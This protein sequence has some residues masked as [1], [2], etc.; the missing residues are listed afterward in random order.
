MPLKLPVSPRPRHGT[1]AV[2]VEA[3][4]TIVQ[5]TTVF[6]AL[7]GLETF[8]QLLQRTIVR[9]YDAEDDAEEPAAAQVADCGRSDSALPVPLRWAFSWLQ[10]WRES[11]SSLE[12]AHVEGRHPNC[13]YN[14]VQTARC[15]SCV[16]DWIQHPAEGGQGMPCCTVRLL[17]LHCKQTVGIPEC[18]SG[19]CLPRRA[20]H[21]MD[22]NPLHLQMPCQGTCLHTCQACALHEGAILACRL[23][24]F[25]LWSV[26]SPRLLPA[27]AVQALT[28]TRSSPSI[29]TKRITKSITKNT[30]KSTTR[31]GRLRR[32]SLST[33]Q[34]SQ[35]RRASGTGVCCWTRGAITCH[36][37]SSRCGSCTGNAVTAGVVRSGCWKWGIT[38]SQDQDQ[39]LDL[40]SARCKHLDVCH[41]MRQRPLAAAKH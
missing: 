30:T 2:Q 18:F 29:T 27:C 33:Q 26:C 22:A 5:A 7:R 34:P 23:H 40:F 14:L 12:E 11:L 15:T 32:F 25:R 41:C 20:L 38:A 6:G 39:G 8:S 13:I 17:G 35:M 10:S 37:Q 28:R 24:V 16:V 4:I 3:P 19:E 1:S 36:C 21:K 31:R 9:E